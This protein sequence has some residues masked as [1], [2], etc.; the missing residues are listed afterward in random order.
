MKHSARPLVLLALV[1]IIVLTASTA[2][3]VGTPSGTTISNGATVDYAVGGVAQAQIASNIASFLVDNRVDLT[4][5][6][7]DVGPITVLPGSTL[8]VLTYQVQNDGN[9]IQDFRL[10]A[11]DAAAA[12]FGLTETID[13]VNVNVFV[14]GNGN[15]TYEPA[16]DT[17]TWVDEMAADANIIAFVVADIPG[18]AVINDVASYDLL[19]I[20]ATAAT[21]GALGGDAVEDSGVADDPNAVQIVFGDG[22]GTID[23]VQDGQFSS[24]DSYQVANANVTLAKS[25]VVVEDPFN[26]VTNPKAI[27]GARVT[28]TIDLDN[29]GSGN[30]DN[31]SIVDAIPANTVFRVGSAVSNG[32][33]TYS[34]DGGATW[35]YSPVADA[36]GND[37]TVSHLR[38]TYALL[39]GGGATE[40][41]IFDV[42]I[43]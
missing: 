3:A 6:T 19:A 20:A 5:T 43:Q 1:A 21:P 17:A 36:N 27:P 34:N 15:G 30:A 23:A 28:Y 13:A 31:V 24:R 37:A 10:Q 7:V 26:G 38:A 29:T 42:V 11:I 22:A 39:V 35:V 9:A 4:V 32:T 18:T 41:T 14:D 40:Q 8:R 33:V 12:A 25:S 16:L 2:F